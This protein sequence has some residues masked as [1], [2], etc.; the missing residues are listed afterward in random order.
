M[1]SLCKYSNI[2]GEP[3]KGVHQYRLGGF[4]IVDVLLTGL[5]ALLLNKFKIDISLI[6]IFIILIIIA[7]ILHKMFCVNT[8]LN[9][10]LG[11]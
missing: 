1:S 6:V 11:I 5:L 4:A 7:I 3:G 10:L 8:R 2:F 9:T